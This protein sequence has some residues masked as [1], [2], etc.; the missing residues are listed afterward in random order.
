MPSMETI[1]LTNFPNHY[2]LDREGKP[3]SE[4]DLLRLGKW[5]EKNHKTPLTCTQ[6]NIKEL[7]VST[8]FLGIDHSFSIFKNHRDPELWETIIFKGNQEGD[9]FAQSIYM[10]RY[11][12]KKEADAGHERACELAELGSDHIL[13]LEEPDE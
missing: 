8:I 1:D 2:I 10:E 7:L 12:T 3:V 9:N 11:S 13:S 4:P 6:T 5:F